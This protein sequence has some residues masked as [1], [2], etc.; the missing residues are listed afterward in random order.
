MKPFAYA[1]ALG[2]ATAQLASAALAA[3]ITGAGA[4]FPFP[5]YSKWAEAYR[6]ESGLGL[7]Y[8]S[9]GS[10]GGVKQILAKTVD[11]GATD[12]PLKGPALEKDGLVQFPTVMGGVVTVV[13][14]AGVEPGKLKLT[15]EIVA[16]IYAGK[17]AKWSDARIAKL[18][19]GVKLPD[20]NITPVYRSDASGTTN[21][22]TTYLSQV[23]ESWKKEFGAA[24]TVSWPAG[25]GGKG[26]EGVTATV[27][28]VPNAIGYV[29]SAYAKQNK[30][31]HT[32]LQNKAGKFPQPDDKAFQAAAAS[33]DWKSAPGF[34][35]S[36]TNQAGEDAWPITAATFILVYKEPA[37]PAKTADVLKFFD[38]A[39]KNGDKLATE[40]DYVPLPDKVVDLIHTEWKEIKGKDGKVVFGK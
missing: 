39:Y 38:W 27:K 11:F 32:L 33:A 20:A 37:D 12:A 36:L 25:Q 10:G 13:N 17:I 8:Q 34:G 31:S 5:V 35:I 23:S 4:T 1:L 26:N 14:I 29:E 21:I 16:D 18:N 40:L 22:F 30:L 15:G 24:T 9:I 6:K 19:E 7:N 28:Q 3:D 2:L